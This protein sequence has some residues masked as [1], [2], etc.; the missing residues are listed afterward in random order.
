MENT[1]NMSVNLGMMFLFF[2]L[3]PTFF[4]IIGYILSEFKTVHVIEVN[5]SNDGATDQPMVNHTVHYHGN[6]VKEASKNQKNKK[7]KKKKSNKKPD[8]NEA[9]G[10]ERIKLQSKT[11]PELLSRCQKAL[12]KLGFKSREAK[13]ILSKLCIN[14]CYEDETQLIQDCFGARK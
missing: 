13:S 3:L 11:D 6:S 10:I 7:R 14:R 12:V 5:H 1:G 9:F 2:L 4:K 8:L